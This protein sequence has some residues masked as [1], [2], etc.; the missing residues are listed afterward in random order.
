VRYRDSFSGSA[1]LD[2]LCARHKNEVYIRT[3][4]GTFL[5]MV[6]CLH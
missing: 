6:T 5:R 1:P 3:E 2:G 4:A